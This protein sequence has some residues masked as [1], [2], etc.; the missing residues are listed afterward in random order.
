MFKDL[1]YRYI[2][3]PAIDLFGYENVIHIKDAILFAAGIFL[4]ALIMAALSGKN[5][6][7]LQKRNNLGKISLLKFVKSGK[8]YILSNPKNS[9]EAIETLLISIFKP[10]FTKKSYTVRDERRTKRFLVSLLIFGIILCLLAAYL[11][12]TIILV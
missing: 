7:K 8:K 2:V 9:G 10:F 12:H 1:L 3:N 5:L 4:G 11:I 6:F